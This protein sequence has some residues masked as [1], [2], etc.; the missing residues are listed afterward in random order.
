[1]AQ[2]LDLCYPCLGLQPSAL[3]QVQDDAY[4]DEEGEVNDGEKEEDD[5]NFQALTYIATI[6]KGDEALRYVGPCRFFDPIYTACDRS[7]SCLH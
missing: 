1:M 7:I 4:E 2:A 6:V 3:L 5:L